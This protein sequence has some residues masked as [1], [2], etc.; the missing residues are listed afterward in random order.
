MLEDKSLD[1]LMNYTN[2]LSASADGPIGLLIEERD[3]ELW[4][5]GLRGLD[6]RRF[7]LWHLNESDQW[8]Y[9]PIPLTERAN[10]PNL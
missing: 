7:G 2:W 8:R 6:Q 3:K 5:M 10:N 4:T 9:L 1:D